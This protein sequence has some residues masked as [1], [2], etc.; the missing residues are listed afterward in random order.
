MRG[1]KNFDSMD[2]CTKEKNSGKWISL[3]YGKSS[4]EK[5]EKK[6]KRGKE[7]R[8]SEL[9]APFTFLSKAFVPQLD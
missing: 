7:K 8:P 6:E 3:V 5:I 4:G 9:D 1:K 2:G